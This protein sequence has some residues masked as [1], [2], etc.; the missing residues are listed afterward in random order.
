MLIYK[1]TDYP[2]VG[3]IMYNRPRSVKS[4]AIKFV[5]VTVLQLIASGLIRIEINEEEA[6]CYCRLVVD[7][8]CPAYLNDTIWDSM[9]LVEEEIN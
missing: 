1:I 4:P 6:K 7:N 9:F 8:L 3:K 5:N 2:E